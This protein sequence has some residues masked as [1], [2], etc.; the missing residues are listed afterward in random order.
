[1]RPFLI[2]IL[3]LGLLLNAAVSF[4]QSTDHWETIVQSS[5]VW[6]YLPATAQP[7]GDWNQPGFDDSAW[8]S[9]K[10]GIGYGDGDDSTVI[11]PVLALYMRK[12]FTVFDSTLLTQ[13]LLH[14]DYDDAFVAYLNGHEIARANIGTPGDFPAYNEGLPIDHEALLYQGITPESFT[15]QK[16]YFIQ[17]QNLLA[18]EVHNV[19]ITSSD[20][21]SNAWLSVGISDS[22]F[23]YT[24][25]P[26][27]FHVI[28][29]EFSSGLPLVLI[30]TRT[31]S[32]CSCVSSITVRVRSIRHRIPQIIMTDMPVSRSGENPQLCFPRNH[33]LLNYRTAPGRN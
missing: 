21:S 32:G 13:A 20:M 31:V 3:S 14:M 33:F 8:L 6:N 16:E 28:T 5:D 15:V 9:G 23:S 2:I 22:T 26:G 10:G 24:P 29:G 1:M 18:I 7:P 25:V 19:G 12:E 17:G 27:W 11:E 4:P 30:D